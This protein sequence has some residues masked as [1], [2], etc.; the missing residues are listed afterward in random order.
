MPH[1]LAVGDTV[2]HF[3]APDQHGR[4]RSFETIR[5]PRGAFIVFIRSADW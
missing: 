1:G 3:Q 2:P 5:G 4:L